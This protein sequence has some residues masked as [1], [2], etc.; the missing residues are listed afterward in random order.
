MCDKKVPCVHCGGCCHF[1][2][3]G[4]LTPEEDLK[5]KGQVYGK[6]GIIY[7]YPFSRYTITLSKNE[8]D[9]LETKAKKNNI[10]ISILPKKVFY[11]IDNDK[12]Y[13]IDYFLDSDICPF[14]KEERCSVYDNRPEICRQFPNITMDHNIDIEKIIGHR[15]IRLINMTIPDIVEVI[16]EKLVKQGVSV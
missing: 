3:E 10:D 1:R 16:K 13:V 7:L 11:D 2:E 9:V 6:T 12:V 8:K 14:W 4:F 15:N 5:I